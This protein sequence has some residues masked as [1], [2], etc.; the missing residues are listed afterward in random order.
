MP[1]FV[2]H[3]PAVSITPATEL[4]RI[5]C[6]YC[7]LGGCLLPMQKGGLEKLRIEGLRD[8][9]PCDRCGKYFKLIIRVVVEGAAIEGEN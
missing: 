2:G 8:P 7:Q 1:T 4:V 3:A 6:P 9:H 5:P